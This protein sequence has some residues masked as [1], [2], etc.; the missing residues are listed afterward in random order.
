MMNGEQFGGV[1]RAVVAPIVAFA[2]GKGWIG[3][4]DVA[5]VVS[6]LVVLATALWSWKTNKPKTGV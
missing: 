1:I 2:A 5:A 6:G 4:A 3:A